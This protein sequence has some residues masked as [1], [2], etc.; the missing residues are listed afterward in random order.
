MH[1]FFM[2]RAI[3]MAYEGKHCNDGGPFGAVIAENDNIICAVHNIVSL[4]KDVTLHAELHAIQQA[5]K[6]LKSKDLSNC[7]LYTSCEPCMMCLGACHWA[8]FKE[9]YYGASANDARLYGFEYSKMY[10]SSNQEERHHEFRMKQLLRDD[11]LAVW[12]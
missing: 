1:D 11:A 6:K 3:A 8:N 9:I 2:Q 10:Y 7:I 5:S 4:H 12:L